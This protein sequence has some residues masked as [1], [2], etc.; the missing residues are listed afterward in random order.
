MAQ[1]RIEFAKVED[2]AR[3]SA[4]TQRVIRISNSVDYGAEAAEAVAQNFSP[5]SMATKIVE[6]HTLM[7]FSGEQLVGTGAVADGYVKTLFVDP[8]LQGNGIGALLMVALEDFARRQGVEHL[9]VESSLTAEKFYLRIG[10]RI[11]KFQPDPSSA[12]FL[13]VKDL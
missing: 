4:L 3:L 6:R 7:C 8:S 2:A 13:M 10:Y 5:E 9:H 11:V 12:T 1:Y